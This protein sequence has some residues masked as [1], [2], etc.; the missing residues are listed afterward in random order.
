MIWRGVVLVMVFVALL[1]V[2][3][4]SSPVGVSYVY[5]DSMEPT[6]ETNDGYI[7]VP[8]YGVGTGDVVTFRSEERD[9]YLTHRIVGV[10]EQGYVTRGDNNRVTDQSAGHS[11]VQESDIVGKVF[12]FRG[13]VVTIPNL[14][15]VFETLEDNRLLVAGVAGILLLLSFAGGEA[16][17]KTRSSRGI[18]RNGDVLR[19]IILVGSVFVIASVVV[20][21]DVHT[22]N[23]V[24]VGHST[25][26]EKLLTVGEPATRTVLFHG[27]SP[28]FMHRFV[29]AEGMSISEINA[30]ETAVKLTVDVPPPEGVG[31][32]TKSVLIHQYP[33][34]LPRSVLGWLHGVSPMAAVVG[35]VGML[36]TP[37]YAVAKIAVDWKRPVRHVKRGFIGR[38]IS[39]M[40]EE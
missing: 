20:S 15:D 17:E 37:M 32:H 36:L 25:E 8:A 23:Y 26:G 6:I 4:V 27:S 34:T 39:E 19:P 24:A 9:E 40:K 30:N 10:T 5:S 18:I 21:T 12:S 1:S 13:S 28:S 33:A 2:L 3:P 31:A 38:I 22:L 11:Y 7:L 35:S 29:S 16:S 14:G